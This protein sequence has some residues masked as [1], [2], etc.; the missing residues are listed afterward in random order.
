MGKTISEKI[1]RGLSL[2]GL[3][4]F[5]I[6]WVIPGHYPPWPSFQQEILAASG[7]F[8][9]GISVLVAGGRRIFYWPTSS[10]LI[11]A[12][13]FFPAIQWLAGQIHY[14]SGLMLPIGYLVGFSLAVVFFYNGI[15]GDSKNPEWI[16]RW[17]SVLI[18]AASISVGLALFQW[19]GASSFWLADVR[20]GG[21]PY[22]NIGQPNHLATLCGLGLVGVWLL[23]EV[24]T[25][26]GRIAWLLIGW[27]ILGLTMTQS[28]T[29]WL[30]FVSLMGF[31]WFFRRRIAF[32]T[33]DHAWWWGIVAFISL[34]LFWPWVNSLL[35]ISL[36]SPWDERISAGTRGPLWSGLLEAIERAPWFGW[37][38]G[39]TSTA[40]HAV[41]LDQDVGQRMLNYAHNIFIDFCLWIGV[42]SALFLLGGFLVWISHQVRACRSPLQVA[43]LGSIL[44]IT[45]H[46][47]TEYPLAYLYFLLPLGMFV[48]ILEAH[49]G[50]CRIY[51][52]GKWVF[53]LLML[54]GFLAGVI[55]YDHDRF[56]G[57]ELHVR[58]S[59]AKIGDD[60]D[61]PVEIPKALLLDQVEA[62]QRLRLVPAR[63]GMS[64][65]ELEEM[66][67]I[68]QQHP[69]PPAL[70]RYALAIA[71]NDRPQQ[72]HA[73]LLALCHLH[74][75]VR[76]DEARTSWR[77][78]QERYPNLEEVA[79]P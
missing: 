52:H 55:I 50:S 19:Q 63:S 1:S 40:Q 45:V 60:A 22:A 21:R 75:S 16:L 79:A 71:L 69:Y 3:L 11:L 54:V 66:K 51:V 62:Y 2:F 77:L 26:S 4:F 35:L 31:G 36:E 74:P 70:L 42:P 23:Y 6:S 44:V 18:L 53:A 67:F 5:L 32:R 14:L 10:L 59:Q 37:G 34:I 28:R 24:Q 9:F 29:G 48:G 64:E 13:T 17:F 25:V 65:A 43:A 7:F 56:E 41:A 49:R 27:L 76:C 73:E 46:S 30:F 68:V 12:L 72:A 57:S 33:P 38:W 78:A 20:P 58:M 15:R 47:L 61:R 8:L 39:Q